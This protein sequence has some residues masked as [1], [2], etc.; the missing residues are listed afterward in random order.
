[1]AIRDLIRA[2]LPERI[3]TSVSAVR[4]RKHSHGLNAEWGVA[5]L[6][7]TLLDQLGPRVLEGPFK[8][9]EIPRSVA[10]EHL[11]PYLLGIYERELHPFLL[12]LAPGAVP[13]IVNVGAKFGYY[14]A[15][16][17][18]R[19]D[20]PA[21]AFDA[22]PWARAR[23]RETADLNK[24]PVTI[25]GRCTR[26]DLENLPDGTLVVIDCDGCEEVLLR[27][28]VPR[29]ILRSLVIVELHDDVM[30]GDDVRGTLRKSHVVKEVPSVNALAPPAMLPAQRKLAVEE[31]RPKQRWL[32]CTPR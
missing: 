26:A 27:D 16:L 1:M 20:A 13:L 14:S 9:L 12:S 31:L 32:I 25:R 21:I 19:L 5:A 24:V 4:A 3:L 10:A 2:L 17:A 11:G 7:K 18:R 28:P 15:G 6:S 29:G 30:N 8:G 23:L 22:D